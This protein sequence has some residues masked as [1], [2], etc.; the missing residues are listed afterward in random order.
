M[1]TTTPALPGNLRNQNTN[2]IGKGPPQREALFLPFFLIS[3]SFRPTKALASPRLKGGRFMPK[4]TTYYQLNQYAPEDHFLREGFN[5]D[6]ATL[7]AALHSK[8][9]AEDLAGLLTVGV[10]AG[11][12]REERVISLGFRP[13]AVVTAAHTGHVP[14]R[15]Q[16]G[17]IDRGWT[18]YAEPE[19]NTCA[20]HYGGWVCHSSR[21]LWS[22]EYQYD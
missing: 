6:N 8:A 21:Q 19:R 15:I 10:Y 2:G 5:A 17:W 18:P 4:K 22:F 3:V 16:L 9:E 12:G 13:R 11:D 7:D 14:L 20:D 1:S